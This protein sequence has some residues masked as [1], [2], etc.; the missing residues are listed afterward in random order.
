MDTQQKWAILVNSKPLSLLQ[1]GHIC[2][3]VA[4]SEESAKKICSGLTLLGEVG[5][6]LLN[7][8]GQDYVDKHVKEVVSTIISQSKTISNNTN[9]D[10]RIKKYC[11]NKEL[12]NIGKTLENL[13]TDFEE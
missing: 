5:Y 13:P 3:I 2:Y 8:E 11:P 4:Y 1:N 9:K 12:P 6:I 10:I 7:K